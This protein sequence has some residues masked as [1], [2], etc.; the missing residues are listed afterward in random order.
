MA[1]CQTIDNGIINDDLF[2]KLKNI[3]FGN[4]YRFSKIII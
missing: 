3:I 1:K 2:M 4:K